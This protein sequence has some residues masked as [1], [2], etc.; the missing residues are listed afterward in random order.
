MIEAVVFDMDG[1]LFDTERLVSECWEEVAKKHNIEEI[2]TILKGCIGLNKKATQA[3]FLKQ[4][5]ETFDFAGFDQMAHEAFMGKVEKDGLP[6]KRGVHEL[7]AFLKEKGFRIGLASSTNEKSVRS[8]LKRAQIESYFEVIVGGD[9]VTNS[10]PDPEIYL[11]ACRELDVS[12]QNAIAIEDSHNGIRAASA[13]GMKVIMV[14]DLMPCNV[15]V[16]KML[17]HKM[18]SLLEVKKFLMANE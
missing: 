4:F 11:R 1:I 9:M 16:E 8:H 18:D 3:I 6:I 14:P 7:L 12:P 17:Y 13:A 2:Q 10:K 5:G 15:E